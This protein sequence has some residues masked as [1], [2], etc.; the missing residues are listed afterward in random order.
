VCAGL[1][2]LSASQRH[3]SQSCVHSVRGAAQ[4]CIDHYGTSGFVA[5][6]PDE[7]TGGASPNPSIYRN[8][9]GPELTGDVGLGNMLNGTVFEGQGQ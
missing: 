3:L 8:A 4:E 9:C 2:L 6:G 5:S 1:Q 7:N